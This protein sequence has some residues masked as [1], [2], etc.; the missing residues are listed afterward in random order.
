MVPEAVAASAE[1]VHLAHVEAAVAVAVFV[2]VQLRRRL[3]VRAGDSN[4]HEHTHA[5]RP[6]DTAN[7]V[8]ERPLIPTTTQP[9]AKKGWATAK[10]VS[11]T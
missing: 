3:R 7:A 11:T 5:S 6:N 8:N 10:W 4:A 2:R 9:S 1:R